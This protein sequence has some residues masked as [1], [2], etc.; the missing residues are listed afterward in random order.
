[1]VGRLYAIFKYIVCDNQDNCEV[2]PVFNFHSDHCIA[3]WDSH[4]R[5]MPRWI[6]LPIETISG[7]MRARRILAW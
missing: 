1:V 5:A 2:S 7:K 4:F 6:E 3:E